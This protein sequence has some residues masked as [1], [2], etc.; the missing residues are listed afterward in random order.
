MSKR[1]ATATAIVVVPSPAGD[2]L[3]RLLD[4]ADGIAAAFLSGYGLATREACARNLRTWG[5]F[6]KTH[7]VEPLEAHHVHV[8]AFARQAEEV[9]RTRPVTPTRGRRVDTT[10]GGTRSTARQPTRWRHMSLHS[11]RIG[12]PGDETS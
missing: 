10:A 3:D 4:T 5:A 9:G 8:D 7:S 2:A 1:P 11:H 12:A 6:L